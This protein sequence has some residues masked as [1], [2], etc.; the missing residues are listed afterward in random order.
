MEMFPKVGIIVLNYNGAEYLLACLQSLYDLEYPYKD[1]IVVDNN[2]D[3][4]SMAMAQHS[5]PQLSFIKNEE[6]YGFA[7][8]M[9]IGI[10]HA[11]TRGAEWCWLF[12]A[13]AKADRQSLKCLILASRQSASVLL[14]PTIFETQRNRLWF[15]KGRVNFFRMRAEHVL[16]TKEECGMDQYPSDFLTGCAMLIH[17]DLIKHIGFLDERFFLYYED[18]DY[19]LRARQAGFI[20]R[21]VTDARVE[22]SEVSQM[23]PRKTYFLVFSGLMFFQRWTPVCMRPSM[24]IYLGL[25]II[26]NSVDRGWK[27]DPVTRSVSQAYKDYFYG[28]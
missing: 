14:S 6:N 16:P 23:S 9:N 11:L 1:I 24:W 5:F 20:P 18:V 12:N 8:G 7:R 19:S 17:R 13:D 4:Q 10:I 21:V 15:A 27:Q 3:D 25:R 22:H 26:K 28:K 2:S